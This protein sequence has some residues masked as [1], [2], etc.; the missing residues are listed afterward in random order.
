M[1]ENFQASHG[2]L[3]KWK[4]RFDIKFKDVVGE[5]NQVTPKMVA[6]S[7]PTILSKYDLRDI[8]NLDEFGLFIKACLKRPCT[9]EARSAQGLNTA[10]CVE[11]AS[12][13]ATLWE[14]S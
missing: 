10:S 6:A 1:V 3:F 12:P 4:N 8:Y 14:R 13:Q 7:L 2:W 5:G 11:L 9:G